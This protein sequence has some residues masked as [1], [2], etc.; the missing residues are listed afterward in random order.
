[1][2]KY[3]LSVGLIFSVPALA[4]IDKG[5][6]ADG[7]GNLLTTRENVQY[8]QSKITMNWW[9][10]HA[11]CQSIGKE[12]ITLDDCLEKT[13]SGL[14]VQCPHLM[15]VGGSS[16]AWTANVPSSTGAYIV[17]LSSGGISGF[18]EGRQGKAAALC[19]ITPR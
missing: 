17:E 5:G 6:C 12:L 16:W 9:S 4:V 15:G 14:K 10:A 3:I 7:Q 2:Y 19:R 1:M 18:Y 11:W 8:C 13:S